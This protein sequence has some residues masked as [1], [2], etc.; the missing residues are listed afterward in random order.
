MSEHSGNTTSKNV[1]KAQA[2]IAELRAEPRE[3][4][5]RIKPWSDWS[6]L[7][8]K[9]FEQWSITTLSGSYSVVR[10][11]SSGVSIWNTCPFFGPYKSF[12]CDS[13]E[14]G[15]LAAEQHWRERIKQALVEVG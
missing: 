1:K 14:S 3:P 11:L 8:N 6:Y 9:D 10:Y 4:V 12:D 2:A 7:K 15:K 13:I 5:Y